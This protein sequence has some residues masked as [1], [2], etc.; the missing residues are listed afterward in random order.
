MVNYGQPGRAI[1]VETEHRGDTTR[2]S[3]LVLN[4]S[5]WD[6]GQYACKP[7]NAERVSIK[8]HVLRSETPAAMQT[9][10]SASPRLCTT[11]LLIFCLLLSLLTP[12]SSSSSCRRSQR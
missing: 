1:T 6:S 10:T 8:V 2:S 12:V 3:L 9:T 4:A 11:Y 5:S 7:S